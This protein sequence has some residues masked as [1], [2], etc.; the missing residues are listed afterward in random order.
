MLIIGGENASHF[1][2]R[3]IDQTL[4]LQRVFIFAR[5]VVRAGSV[6]TYRRTRAAARAVDAANPTPAAPASQ[7]RPR[8][9]GAAFLSRGMAS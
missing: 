9:P 5:K 7:R 1:G 2:A 3:R 6:S 4:N 8:M